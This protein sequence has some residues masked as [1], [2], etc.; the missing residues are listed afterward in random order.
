MTMSTDQSTERRACEAR[1]PGNDV[2]KQRDQGNGAQEQKEKWK[3][4]PG[5]V[6]AVAARQP[7]YDKEIETH[8]RCDLRHL[9]D[10]YQVDAEPHEIKSG[11]RG[12]GEN[13]G[14]REHDHGNAVEKTPENNKK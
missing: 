11:T 1:Q 12:D 13:H 8:W 5:H 9:N 14:G 3:G 6:E 7:L 2:R 4:R 10:Q